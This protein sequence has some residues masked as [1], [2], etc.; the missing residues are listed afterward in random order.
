MSYESVPIDRIVLDV[1][2]TVSSVRENL[3]YASTMLCYLKSEDN[4]NRDRVEYYRELVGYHRGR[5]DGLRYVLCQ[6]E[7]EY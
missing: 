1:K 7:R 6:L 2:E 5:L 4:P 3:E